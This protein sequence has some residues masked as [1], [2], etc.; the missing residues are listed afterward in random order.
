MTG[1]ETVPVDADVDDDDV[2]LQRIHPYIE[3]DHSKAKKV[4]IEFIV[5]NKKSADK[6][7]AS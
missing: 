1:E 2:M 5:G 7:G 4:I 3:R 6:I